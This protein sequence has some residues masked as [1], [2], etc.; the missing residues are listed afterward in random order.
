MAGN[1][2]LLPGGA[3]SV[4]PPPGGESRSAPAS[5]VPRGQAAEPPSSAE[6]PPNVTADSD[7]EPPLRAPLRLVGM[8]V[9]DT[10]ERMICAQE[11]NDSSSDSSRTRGGSRL[12]RDLPR[13]DGDA[14]RS[15][16][17]AA[18]PGAL[19]SWCR[20]ATVA[21]MASRDTGTGGYRALPGACE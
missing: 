6:V 1:P 7:R 18:K 8:A 13:S 9:R 17:N 10:R 4:R 5:R 3:P 19:P 15:P 14:L 2:L 16:G 11:V 20:P 12:L 21:I